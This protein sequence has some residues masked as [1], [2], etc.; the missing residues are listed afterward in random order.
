[1][2]LAPWGGVFRVIFLAAAAAER[3]D[4]RLAVL[5]NFGPIARARSRPANFFFSQKTPEDAGEL[6]REA[7]GR[8]AYSD[9]REGAVAGR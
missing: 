2:G 6:M 3:E 9:T 4:P 8:L 1:M 7:G 5:A